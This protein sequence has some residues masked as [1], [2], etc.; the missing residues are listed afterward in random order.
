V[1]KKGNRRDRYLAPDEEAV[2]QQKRSGRKL[3]DG[4]FDEKSFRNGNR[5]AKPLHHRR[6]ENRKNKRGRE[7]CRETR[8]SQTTTQREEKPLA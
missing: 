3:A 4:Q 5:R 6:T 8:I 1:K 7:A 2:Q